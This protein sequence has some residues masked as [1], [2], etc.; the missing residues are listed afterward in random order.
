MDQF[1]EIAN[2][3]TKKRE[4][5]YE[6]Q[7]CAHDEVFFELERSNKKL[8]GPSEIST[9]EELYALLGEELE[10]HKPFLAD[11]CHINERGIVRTELKTFSVSG[12]TVEIPDY[13]GP[14]GNAKKVYETEFSLDKK[15]GKRYR[16]CFK[17]VDYIAEVYINGEFVGRHEGFFAPFFFDITDCVKSGINTLKVVVKNDF[18]YLGNEHQFNGVSVQGDKL[19]A[20]TG[21]GWDDPYSGWHHCPPGFGILDK[22][23]IEEC[24]DVIINDVFVRVLPD[25]S[26]EAWVELYNFGYTEYTPVISLGVYGQNF[27]ETVFENLKFD[28]GE[29]IKIK[30]RE[31][32][33]KIPFKIDNPK[34]WT[35]SEPWLYKIAVRLGGN[36]VQ[37]RTR[38]FGVRTFMQDT[39]SEIKGA[40]YLNGEKIKLR[41]AN[42]M[43]FEQQD[44]MRG[45]YK[46]LIDDILLAKICRMNF[47]RITQRPVQEEI[48]DYCDRLGMLVQ[49]DLPLFGVMRRTKFAEGVRQA[50][51]MERLVRSHPS[52]I[53]DTFINEPF[54]NGREEPHRHMT[55]PELEAFF[56]ACISIIKMSNPERVIKSVD[57]DYDAPSKDMPDNHC[58]TMWYYNHGVEFGKLNKGFWQY[59]KKD[60]YYGCGEFGA[61]GLD[62]VDLMRRRYPKEWLKEPFDPKNIL[63]SQTGSNYM[64]FF[65]KPTGGIEDWVE[66]SRNHQAYATKFMTEHFR[67]DNLNVSFAVHLFID[68]WPA[69]WMK[70]IM[71]CERTPKPAYFAYRNALKPVIV[72]LRTDRYTCFVGEDAKIECFLC[73]DLIEPLSGK[74]EYVVENSRGETILGGETNVKCAEWQSNY[75]HTVKFKIDEVNGGREK[76]KVK[77]VYLDGKNDCG[78]EIEIEVFDKIGYKKDENLEIVELKELGEY[79]I[80]GCKVKV[81]HFLVGGVFFLETPQVPPFKGLLRKGDLTNFYNKDL[82]RIDYTAFYSF[83][84]EGFTPLLLREQAY[85]GLDLGREEVIS[86]K[87]VGNKTVVITTMNLRE[88]NP[89]VQLL[90]KA[91][92]ENLSQM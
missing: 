42:T 83:V 76:F 22:V 19:Y 11:F 41:G 37:V 53:L 71:D 69:G 49:T 18:V 39:T 77:V 44:V 36:N 54:A 73:N 1:I 74:I 90:L 16:V 8:L 59:I 86:Y 9:K 32:I 2:T 26:L 51:E 79:E 81:Q 12:K 75:L 31:N 21:P 24:D 30:N 50:E 35:T 6:R 20:A 25:Y 27:K 87:R 60:W 5:V 45:D 58:Y 64:A 56:D 13:G 34:I 47:L 46:Q 23:F 61:E 68:A 89:A 66:T 14:C 82:D 84:S 48:Y 17:S 29:T 15:D 38:T 33:F 92:N 57:G 28:V 62:T 63:K 70:T 10:R 40:F 85:G 78:N 43:G 65:P 52:C 3:Q 67:R 4:D 7:P 55:R 88:E 72:S 80:E 91:L